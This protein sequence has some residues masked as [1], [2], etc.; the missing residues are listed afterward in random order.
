VLALA[1]CCDES[2][3]SVDVLATASV[4]GV[5]PLVLFIGDS[6][7]INWVAASRS[8]VPCG[9]FLYSSTANPDRFSFR[10]TDS[11]VATVGPRSV[12]TARSPG[13]TTVTATTAGLTS[14]PLLV[15]VEPR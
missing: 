13:S 6:T 14:G 7:T 3:N 15:V 10:S 11:V 2:V 5:S 8:G 12:L 9:R 4:S 1:A